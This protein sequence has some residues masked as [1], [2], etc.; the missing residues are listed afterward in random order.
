VFKKNNTKVITFKAIDE[1]VFGV[2]EPPVPAKKV[3]PECYKKQDKLTTPGIFTLSENGNPNHTVKACMP[4]FDVITAG[5]VF[6]LPVDIYFSKDE[7]GGINSQWS[8]NNLRAIETHPVIQYSEYTVPEGYNK[9]AF[10]FIQPW[11]V[12]TPPGYS[13]L[14]IQPALR[15]DLPFQVIPAIVDT[16]KHPIKVNFPFFLKENFE[17]MLEMGTPIMQIIPFKREDWNH[18]IVE[19]LSQNN[20]K[21][22]MSAERKIGN[23]YKSFFRTIKRWD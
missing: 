15:D 17:G 4:V 10:K 19:D 5:Y 11:V 9:T 14:F 7:N 20:N 21:M 6:R 12:E 3:L 22:W 16:D 1:N 23:R 18:E 13:C 2:F 8:S